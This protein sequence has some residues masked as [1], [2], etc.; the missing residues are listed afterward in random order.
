M[1]YI[2]NNIFLKEFYFFKIF[3]KSYI[4][5]VV[6]VSDVFNGFFVCEKRR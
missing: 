6:C 5:I 3:K 4:R 1:E 2:D